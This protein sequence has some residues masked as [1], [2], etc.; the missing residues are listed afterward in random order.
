MYFINVFDV[1][2]WKLIWKVSEEEFIIYGWSSDVQ[3]YVWVR[4]SWSDGGHANWGLRYPWLYPFRKVSPT[5]S[6][7]C[8]SLRSSIPGKPRFS[9]PA[10]VWS[11]EPIV[12]LVWKIFMHQMLGKLWEFSDWLIHR[13]SIIGGKER[14][15]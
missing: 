14:K 8:D 4:S 13:K 3:G 11:R 1:T 2:L 7:N 5:S 10:R 12:L 15:K 6:D 9:P